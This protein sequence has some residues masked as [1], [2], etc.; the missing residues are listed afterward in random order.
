MSSVIFS[1]WFRIQRT[2]KNV[3]GIIPRPDQDSKYDWKNNQCIIQH[4][5]QDS[6]YNFKKSPA[7]YS[8]SGSGFSVQLKNDT[9]LFSIQRTI[10]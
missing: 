10:E 2:I 3:Q 1:A 9:R 6:E 4:L 7:Y 5:V 8:A